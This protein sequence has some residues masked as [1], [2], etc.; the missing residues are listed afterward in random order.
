MDSIIAE[1]AARIDRERLTEL[2]AD[3]V[4][5]YSPSFAEEPATRVF[6]RHLEANGIPYQRQPVAGGAE[7][8]GIPRANLIVRLG[9]E[10]VRLLWVGHVD[11][12]AAVDEEHPHATISDGL[13][14]GLG[15][16]DMKSGCAAAVEAV[17]ALAA[18]EVELH[19]GLCVALVVGEEEYGDGIDALR[20]TV[21]APLAIVGEPTGLT[22]CLDHYG[23]IEAILSSRGSRAHAA[24]PEVGSSAIHAMLS[25]LLGTLNTRRELPHPE[26]IALNPRTISGGGSL[27]AVAE[28]CTAELDIH[29]APSMSPDVAA[30]VVEAARGPASDEHPGCV[31][32]YAED[33]RHAG[34]SVKADDPRLRPVRRAFESSGLEFRPG[35]F[36]SHSD[37]SPL[38]LDGAAP[39]VCGPGRLEVA[40]TP[41]EHVA[42]DEVE[43]A[44]H[45]Y[46]AM[47]AHACCDSD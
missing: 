45:L 31:L 32:E 11:T 15:A 19:H 22:P 16:A 23:Y 43:H 29:F 35:T 26:R 8:G 33:Y 4:D 20:E 28:R 6:A 5:H 46:A 1:I 3:A 34:W 38:F 12:V 39:I 42:L 27:F 13:L 36:R 17:T 25:W 24:L 2:L 41:H 37:A 18:S 21:H 14:H 9:P 7:G 44:A 47:F 10:P 40:H 30:E